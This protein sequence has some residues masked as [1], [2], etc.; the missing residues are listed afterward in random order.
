MSGWR[1][2][3]ISAPGKTTEAP[4]SPPIASSA[5]RTLSGMDRLW[6]RWHGRRQLS[7]MGSTHGGDHNRSVAAD[8]PVLAPF[9]DLPAAHDW[10]PPRFFFSAS[11][12]AKGCSPASSTLGGA[13]CGAGLTRI[14]VDAEDQEFGRQ[15]AQI[16]R[17]VDQRFRRLVAAARA[18]AGAFGLRLASPLGRREFEIDRL[19]DRAFDRLERHH[20]G[21][22]DAGAHLAGDVHAGALPGQV[23]DG[24]ELRQ[25]AQRRRVRPA[26]RARRP[27]PRSP[28]AGRSPGCLPR[29]PARSRGFRFSSSESGS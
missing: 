17:A 24:R 22:A 10:P 9:H 11:S 8:K 28:Y 16:E 12:A 1:V 18:F 3:E 4:W 15:R 6:R 25:F 5:M 7:Q 2:S 29:P 20:A 19:L 23:E 27:G 26:R 21:L 14:G 13:N